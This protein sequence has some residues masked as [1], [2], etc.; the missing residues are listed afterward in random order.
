MSFV[1]LLVV[2]TGERY[3]TKWTI[4]LL[5]F[6]SSRVYSAWDGCRP[7]IRPIPNEAEESCLPG[8]LLGWT[9]T[10]LIASLIIAPAVAVGMTA[11]LRAHYSFSCRYALTLPSNLTHEPTVTFGGSCTDTP[12]GFQQWTENQ[13]ADLVYRSPKYT[14]W[15]EGSALPYIF[16]WAAIGTELKFLLF[17]GLC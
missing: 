12:Y 8:C 13:T 14:W 1:T 16:P 4:V 10:L 2:A 9:I 6:R 7:A 3:T 5:Y 11:H 15:R 17:L